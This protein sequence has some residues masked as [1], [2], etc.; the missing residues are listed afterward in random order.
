MPDKDRWKADADTPHPAGFGRRLSIGVATV[1]IW[2]MTTAGSA[3]LEAFHH[4]QVTLRPEQAGLSGTD[5]IV[6]TNCVRKK[7]TIGLNPHLRITSFQVNGQ[8]RPAVRTDGA[9]VLELAARECEAAVELAI[10][11]AGQ[12]K[13][14]AP[15]RPVNTDNPGYG[16]SG[17]I[18]PR[19]TLL[20]GGAGWYPAIRD[21]V[22]TVHLQVTAPKG[23]SAVTAGRALEVT[24]T[25]DRTV[26]TW[27]V[28]PPAGRLS[29]S[30]GRYIITSSSADNIP[31]ATYFLSDDRDLANTY[32]QATARY[33]SLYD[34]LF[35][36]YAFPKFAVVE[37]FF[38]TG[39][40]FPSYTLIGGRVLRLPFIVRTSLGHEIAHC[41]WGN[42][43][44]V[45][46][47]DGNWSEG[48]TSYVAEHLYQEMASPEAARRDRRQLLRNYATIAAPGEDFPLR[49]FTGR[50][51]PLTQVI[52]YDKGA[53]VFHMLRQTIGNDAF[54]EGLRH[55]YAAR[56]HRTADWL[57]LQRAFEA[58]G[59]REL[60]WFFHQWLDRPGAPVLWLEDVQ[61]R[62]TGPATYRIEGVLRQKA[63]FYRLTVPLKVSGT[64]SHAEAPVLI[65]GARAPFALTLKGPPVRLE[66]DPQVDVFRRLAPEE[67]PAAINALKRDAPLNVVVSSGPLSST[68]RQ[69]VDFLAQGLGRSRVVARREA[70]LDS[71]SE[72]AGDWLF[73]GL[74]TLP[75]LKKRVEDAVT[76]RP[77]GFELKG[78]FFDGR[79]ASFFGVWRHPHQSGRFVAVLIPGPESYQTAIARKIPH[80]GR[81]SYLVFEDGTNKIKGEWPPAA[82]PLVYTW[83]G[84]K[85]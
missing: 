68:G 35:G 22:E 36:P 24:T 51:S 79:R 4:L 8:S 58:T 10:H 32:L 18:G 15:E 5:R 57:T 31:T 81:Y 37:N 48:L 59:R 12:F 30:A 19:G 66:A 47:A 40:G 54:W 6:I 17:T 26:S 38:P 28:D 69:T 67:I 46:P 33:L 76:P 50:T 78:Q 11:Y 13:D 80:Y 21:A 45:D 7:L 63:P 14:Q 65:E 42:G 82:S 25:D 3:A 1:A 39:Y 44:L 70:D 85:P 52:G 74:P 64:G 77:E 61:T 23:V 29:L 20:L 43:V 49:R 60:S 71:E 75:T 53:M 27:Q 9:L 73:W 41:W 2:L 16:V 83:P 55:L 84:M 56:L 62:A 34:S 72:A